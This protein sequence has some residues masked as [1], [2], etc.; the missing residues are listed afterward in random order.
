MY[1]WAAIL[2]VPISGHSAYSADDLAHTISL[3]T[4]DVSSL[5]R[6]R[7]YPV[8]TGARRIAVDTIDA[9]PLINPLRLI[10]GICT[11]HKPSFLLS[12][13]TLTVTVYAFSVCRAHAGVVFVWPLLWHSPD[14]WR[15]RLLCLYRQYMTNIPTFVRG[16]VCQYIRA[17]S[18]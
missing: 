14:V 16:L 8:S 15:W 1:G 11:I 2:L 7:K 13:L 6:L 10:F 18:L 5:I 4:S 9:P 12:I 17:S 3:S